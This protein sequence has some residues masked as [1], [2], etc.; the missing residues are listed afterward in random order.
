[1]LKYLWCLQVSTTPRK[2]PIMLHRRTDSLPFLIEYFGLIHH[3]SFNRI[4]TQ[5]NRKLWNKKTGHCTK[6]TWSGYRT[7]LIVYT[8]LS[9]NCLCDN[10]LLYKIP[11]YYNHEHNQTYYLKCRTY[12]N[13]VNSLWYVINIPH[14]VQGSI[15]REIPTL[16]K[17]PYFICIPF[18]YL[19]F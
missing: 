9:K 3:W 4:S 11:K 7:F 5:T 16:M 12:F 13:L 6:C 10:S 18:L 17:L 2:W 1:M 19:F 14:N 8:S 15:C